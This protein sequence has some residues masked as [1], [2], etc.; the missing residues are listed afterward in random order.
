M[1]EWGKCGGA[2]GGGVIHLYFKVTIPPPPQL[3][4]LMENLETFELIF[5]EIQQI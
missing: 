3:E 1:T 4:L 5:L 2:G